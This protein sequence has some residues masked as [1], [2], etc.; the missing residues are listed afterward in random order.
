MLI[1]RA[2]V[3]EAGAQATAALASFD[4]VVLNA[5]RDTETAL[6]A[7]GAELDHHRALLA[8]QKDATDALRLADIQ[9]RSGAASF[10]DLLGSESTQ[11][12]ADQAVA[13]S[14]QTLAADQVAVFQQLGGGWED[15]PAAR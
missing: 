12:A 14:D 11:V 1:A 7:Y 13:L 5:L 15:A 9:F 4:G 10:L 8:A 3:R 6:S 2:H